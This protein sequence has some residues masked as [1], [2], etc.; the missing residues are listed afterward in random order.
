MRFSFRQY[1]ITARDHTF[2]GDFGNSLRME[3]FSRRT[4]TLKLR[5]LERVFPPRFESEMS[6]PFITSDNAPYF[7]RS[8]E[9]TLLPY[10]IDEF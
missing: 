6:S 8:L 2:H 5:A 3:L 1:R 7:F 9:F 10:L 4:E